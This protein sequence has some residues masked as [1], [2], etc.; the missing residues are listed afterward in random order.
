MALNFSYRL[1]QS[2]TA[3]TSNA[4]TDFAAAQSTGG[5]A[6][7]ALAGDA[8]AIYGN[9]TALDQ[10]RQY[11]LEIYAQETNTKANKV[12]FLDSLDLNIGFTGGLFETT[13]NANFQHSSA[14]DLFNSK[15]AVGDYGTRFTAGSANEFSSGTTGIQLNNGQDNFLGRIQVDVN[16]DAFTSG[17]ENSNSASFGNLSDYVAISV[18]SENTVIRTHN[19]ANSDVASLQTYDDYIADRTTEPGNTNHGGTTFSSATTLTLD[20]GDFSTA[21]VAN[22]FSNF[23]SNAYMGNGNNTNLVRAGQTLSGSFDVT[24]VGKAGLT[25]L[26][27]EGSEG[28]QAANTVVNFTSA[29]VNDVVSGSNSTYGI[30]AAGAGAFAIDNNSETDV[31]AI[32]SGVRDNAT[33][34]TTGTAETMTVNFTSTVN[35]AAAAGSVATV[36]FSSLEM[37]ASGES[38]HDVFGDQSAVIKNLVTYRS[39]LTYDGKVGMMDVA[40]LNAAKKNNIVNEYTNVDSDANDVLN[41]NDLQVMAS[42]FGQSLWVNG[43]GVDA[44]YQN[45]A[46]SHDFLTEQN[47]GDTTAVTF[48]NGAFD[49]A[50]SAA[51]AADTAGTLGQEASVFET[52]SSFADSTTNDGAYS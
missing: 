22:A 50:G 11:Y 26:G 31:A 51:L 3:G 18:N 12:Y 2:T 49:D 27:I 6:N 15:I 47:A 13:A 32:E 23:Y 9:G 1:V 21:S 33:G 41:L 34:E 37:T 42:E 39:D 40:V 14:L 8:V 4:A 52:P 7:T 29:T 5:T 43:T 38:A 25:G 44:A 24:N 30:S 17:Y 46:T 45:A 19:N 35:S 48:T 16:D 36:D 10:S 20:S 28:A